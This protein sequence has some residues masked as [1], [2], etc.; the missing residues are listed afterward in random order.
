MPYWVRCR[1]FLL[2]TLAWRLCVVGAWQG[3][4]RVSAFSNHWTGAH[5]LAETWF[6]LL[7]R[8]KP[9]ANAA[10]VAGSGQHAQWSI[11]IM[12]VVFLQAASQSERTW[13]ERLRCLDETK[14][15]DV[16]HDS[17]AWLR[18]HLDLPRACTDRATPFCLASRR[19]YATA[20]DCDTTLAPDQ[21][22]TSHRVSFAA[23][24]PHPRRPHPSGQRA[25]GSI[26]PA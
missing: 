2:H 9:R 13:A 4:A 3:G 26:F 20:T 22:L 1:G 6:L 15:H 8:D 14:R 10:D 24:N 23:E 7:H 16:A 25:V 21:Q 18:A 12:T 19:C 11:T 17:T 5:T